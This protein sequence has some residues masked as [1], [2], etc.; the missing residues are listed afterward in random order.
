[1]GIRRIVVVF[2]FTLLVSHAEAIEWDVL[3]PYGGTI[4]SIAEDRWGNIYVA[5]DGG[6][7]FRTQDRGMGWQA[8]SDGLSNPFVFSLAVTDDGLLLAGTKDGLYET[9]DATKGWKRNA[10]APTGALVPAIF[11]DKDK[12]VYISVW[13]S[14]VFVSRDGAKTWVWLKEGLSAPQVNMIATDST[15]IYAGTDYGLYKRPKKNGAKW[16]SFGGMDEHVVTSI[17]VDPKGNLIGTFWA[18]GIFKWT[19]DGFKPY[20]DV[21]PYSR[22]LTVG[23]DGTIYVASESGVYRLSSTARVGESFG[24]NDMDVQTVFVTSKGKVLA[25]TYQRGVF[26][27]EGS[28]WVQRNKG[29][30][31]HRTLKIAFGKDGILYAGTTKGLYIRKKD[32]GWQELDAFEG[33]EVNDILFSKKGTIF[34]G[35]NHVIYRKDG[36]SGKWSKL[37]D[38]WGYKVRD[39]EEDGKGNIYMATDGD[40]V[41]VSSDGGRSWKPL[42]EGLDNP[43]VMS[44]LS[45]DGKLYAGTFDGVF[46]MEDGVW[47]RT[48]LEDKTVATIIYHSG[49]FYVGTEGDG[50]YTSTDGGEWKALNNGLKSPIVD[51][52]VAGKDGRLYAG[53]FGGIFVLDDKDKWQDISGNLINRMVRSIAF[54]SKGRIHVGTFGGGVSAGSSR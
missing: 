39:L 28:K 43:R 21:E 7:V 36:E 25:G 12:S 13:G 6:G 5:T 23:R 20:R 2:L 48:G 49:R 10:G 32:G 42:T 3:G 19:D 35:T 41:L 37:E 51:T 50:I 53:T 54:D 33:E 27:L 46:V 52:I 44:L 30:V 4:N 24:L 26:V 8:V 18:A 29:I 47:K 45:L 34:V 40:G 38:L 11:V 22:Y 17:I 31:N 9:R 1:M 14:G 15:T 16:V